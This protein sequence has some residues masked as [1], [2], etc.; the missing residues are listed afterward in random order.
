MAR[1]TTRTRQ[2]QESAQN[3]DHA[4]AVFLYINYFRLDN[5]YR[6]TLNLLLFF[7]I[8]FKKSLTYIFMKEAMKKT[9]KKTRFRNPFAITVPLWWGL[10]VFL[11]VLVSVY[12]SVYFETACLVDP[13]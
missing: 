5:I 2:V 7:P 8:T 4:L 6:I 3:S 12:L 10:V 1:R 11:L 13:L 9:V